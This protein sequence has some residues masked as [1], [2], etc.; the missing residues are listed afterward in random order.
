MLKNWINIFI[1]HIKNNKLFTALNVLGLSIGIAGLIFA[2]LYWND[3]QSYDQWNPNKDNIFLVAN[4][5]DATTY[6]ASSSAPIGP[7]I[8]EINPEVASYCY[9]SGDYDNEIIRFNNKK[10][11]SD[12]I[13]AAQKNF[14]EYFPYSFI[15]GNSKTALP[16]INSICLSQD[17]AAQLFGNETALGKQVVLKG[18]NLIVTGVYK[19]DKKSAYNPSCVVNFMD[20]RLKG[21]AQAWGDFQFVLLLKLKNPSEQ[22][23]VTQNLQKIYFENMTS[24]YAKNQGISPEE[25]IKKYGEVKPCLES[26]S[27]IRLHTKTGG[28]AEPKGNYQFL[29]IMVGLSVLILI[30]SIVNYVNSATANAVKRAKE[31]GVR[32]IIGASKTAIVKQFIFETAVI[33]LLSILISLVIVELS[34]PYY[35][36]FLEKSLALQSSQFYLQLVVIFVITVILAGIF[37]AVYVSNF[38]SLKVLKGNFGRSK[39]GVWLRNGMLIFQFAVAAFFIVGS[40]VVYEQIDL[41]NSKDLG[42]NGKQILNISYRNIYGEGITNKDR[43]ERYTIIKNQ[44]QHI[45]GVQQVSSAGFVLGNGARSVISYHYKDLNIDGSNMPIDFGLLEMMK[46]KIV[47]GRSFNPEFAQDTISSMLI[48]ETALKLLNEKD[49]IGKKVHWNGLDAIIVGVVKDFNVGNPGEPIP[50]MSFFHFK[51]VPWFTANLNNIYITADPKTMQQTIAGIENLWIKKVDPDYPFVYD[52]VDKQYK[53]SFSSYVKQK[54]LFSLLNIIVI[55]IALLGL[56]AL[57]SYSIERRMKEIAIRKT[58]G[59]ETNV[60]L[61]ELCKQYILF[62]VVGFLIALFPAYYLLNKWLENFSYRITISI[63][64]FLI[65]FTAL[66]IL[67]L[68]VVLSRAYQATKVD[69]LKYLKYE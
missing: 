44:L 43:F 1:Y 32:K 8:K 68:L 56:F 53:R 17:L 4:Q 15:E 22:K 58:L 40:Y 41:M 67:T 55:T 11:Q 61:K 27:S 28:L 20:E 45:K 5:M 46:I 35:N 51:T 50:P 30:L 59:A 14:F 38:E 63:Y 12:K 16:D 19:L 23:R 65:G 64:P 18:K 47:K 24:R 26:L 57:A 34:L 13:I 69:V 25:F 39:S 10:V 49:P 31:V 3:E 36:A 60:L 29:L 21:N 54:N 62:S 9:L 52:F 6:W 66:L 33:A 7:A 37:P 48:N 42:F 2:I